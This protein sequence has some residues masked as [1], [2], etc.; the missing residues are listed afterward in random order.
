MY[1]DSQIVQTSHTIRGASKISGMGGV[2]I[3]GS[4]RLILGQTTPDENGQFRTE[5]SFDG[6]LAYVNL[7]N[8]QL[9][10][11]DVADIYNDCQSYR[12]GNLVQWTQF[13][14][15]TRGSARIRWPIDIFDSRCF[16]DE[17]SGA[18]CEEFC[19]IVHG[20]F[21]FHFSWNFFFF[22]K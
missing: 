12:C 5:Q 11:E 21:S 4:G 14:V 19:Q 13:R 8:E 7:W 17:N 18:A 6:S 22:Q 15:G 10:A 2:K 3:P 16:D 20:S 1:I 9:S